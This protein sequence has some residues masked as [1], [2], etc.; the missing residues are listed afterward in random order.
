VILI[1][2]CIK[3]IFFIGKEVE[4][5]EDEYGR[6]YRQYRSMALEKLP[7]IRVLPARAVCWG[8]F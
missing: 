2:S 8:V 1:F 7:I 5:L 3:S 4:M 6:K